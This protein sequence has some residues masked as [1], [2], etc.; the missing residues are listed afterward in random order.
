MPPNLDRI[1]RAHPERYEF[2]DVSDDTVRHAKD[3][4]ALRPSWRE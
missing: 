1:E 4:A 3:E 2:S